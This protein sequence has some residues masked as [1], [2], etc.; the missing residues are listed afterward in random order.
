MRTVKGPALFL[1]QFAG[2]DAPFDSW[3]A[4]T[5]WAADCGYVGVQVPSWRRGSVRSVA[6]GRKPGLLRRR[7]PG[8]RGRTASPSPSFRPICRA[9]SSPCTR[10]T[11]TL[12]DAFA[13][14]RGA[15]QPRRAAGLG[16][17]ARCARRSRLAPAWLHR[18]RGLLGRAGLALRL[19]LAAASGGADRGGL[20][21]ARPPLAPA[22]RRGRGERR[23]HRLRDPSRRGPARRRQLRDVPRPRGAPRAG[24]MLYDPSHYL[25]Q[26][27]DY[28]D[29]RH[30]P[31]PDP[32]VPRQ[33]RRAEPDRAAGRLWRLSVLGEP[34]RAVPL[35]RRRAGRLRRGLLQDGGQRLRRL[36][37]GRMGMPAQ[38]PRGR[39]ARGRGGSCATTSS[40][41]PTGPS[42]TSPAPR[43]TGGANRRGFS[44]WRA[45]VDEV[46]PPRPRRSARHGRRRRGRLHRR[47]APHGG[48]ARRA[49]R[50]SSPGA[51]SSTPDRA[52]ASGRALGL[53]EDR[54][55][56]DFGTM[57]AREAARSDGIEAV[58]IVTPNHMHFRAGA[59]FL[60][61]GIHVICDKP[62]P[63]RLDEAR[64]IAEAAAQGGRAL[65]AHAQ[66]HRLSDGAR[67]RAR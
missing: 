22:S 41:S 48:A 66:L 30:L 18:A 54:I 57:A 31:R 11:T 9:S 45:E 1:A 27:L 33:G 39:R 61:R 6:R 64:A 13:A 4:I 59:A 42:T 7:S 34:R 65:R 46:P 10:P 49:V 21:R 50:R 60:K 26:G 67:R 2:D 16:G 5:A 3:D 28:L 58:A 23:R 35:A 40:A 36:G 44:D 19:S 62:L 63:R 15:R 17:R 14:P 29:H 32:D 8:R 20:R 38:A 53:A 43:P 55:Y 51:L 37:G 24:D 12:F 47:G 52:R 25:L 56:D